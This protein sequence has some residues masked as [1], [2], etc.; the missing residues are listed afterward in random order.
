MQQEEYEQ[1]QMQQDEFDRQQQQQLEE[2]E[3]DQEIDEDQYRQEQLEQDEYEGGLEGGHFEEVVDGPKRYHHQN[4]IEGVV[5]DVENAVDQFVG[6]SEVL[7]S[8]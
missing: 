1:Q 7:L 4:F 6:D 3:Y 2:D 5:E 8:N